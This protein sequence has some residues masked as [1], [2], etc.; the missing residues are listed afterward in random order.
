MTTQAI[1]HA[2]VR[3]PG[4][5]YAQA[6]SSTQAR[7]DVA[8]ARKQHAE[9]CEVLRA[10]GLRVEML[11]PAEEFPDSCFMQ[12]P[13]LIVNDVAVKCRMGAPTRAGE[14]RLIENWLTS[15]FVVEEITA[16]GTL[17]GGDVLMT[18]EVIFVGESARTNAAGIAR[19][20]E[21]FER[22]EIRIEP[23]RVEKYLHLLS[24]ATYV[25][26][27]TLL[28]LDDYAEHPAFKGFDILLVSK[29]DAY[30]ADAL[31]VGENVVLPAG[32]PRVEKELHARGFKVLA[33]PMS[34]F[35]KADGGVT[36]LALVW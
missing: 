2:L 16:P 18:P 22:R 19:L 36:C 8:L 5:S 3:T 13:A 31:G 17:E 21:I 12:D 20:K 24:A 4:E 11:P 30:A 6:L 28:A 15:H 32:F 25:G 14:P 1:T 27:N 35:E 29:E 26:N 23:I 10:T 34:E 9:Y 7:I 33:T